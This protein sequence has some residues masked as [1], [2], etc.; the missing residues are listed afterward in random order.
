MDR[1]LVQHEVTRN[2]N[3][4]VTGTAFRKHAGRGIIS[5]ISHFYMHKEDGLPVCRVASGDTWKCKPVNHSEFE[6]I[7]VQ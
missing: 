1:I 6:Y 4:D 3:N 7:T 2:K 5:E